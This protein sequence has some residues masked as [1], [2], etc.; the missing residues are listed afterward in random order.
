MEKQR[1]LKDATNIKNLSNFSIELN[2][3]PRTS[4]L[5]VA[6]R[7]LNPMHQD[8]KQVVLAANREVSFSPVFSNYN[9][10]VSADPKCGL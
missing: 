10:T 5:Q 8:L 9:E 7:A 4:V 1:P 3:I 6:S 2:V